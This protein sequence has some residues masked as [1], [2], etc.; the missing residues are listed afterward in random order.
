[1]DGYKV[2]SLLEASRYGDVF[3]TATGDISVLDKKHFEAMK[4]GAIVANT[5]HFNVEIDISALKKIAKKPPRRIREFVEEYTLKSGKRINVLADGRLVNL[6]AAEGHPAHVMDMSFANQAL[7]CLFLKKNAGS[8]GRKV[9]KVPAKIDR[10]IARLKLKS[11]GVKVDSLTAEQRK[12]LSSWE[13]G[14]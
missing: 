9:Y 11:M 4:D 7:G 6:A 10:N 5:G 14:T 2:A 8:L 3:V 13:A 12:Y 1:M